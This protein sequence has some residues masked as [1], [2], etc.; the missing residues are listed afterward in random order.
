[1]ATTG[2]V[3]AKSYDYAIYQAVVIKVVWTKQLTF[4]SW[5]ILTVD[6]D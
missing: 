6:Q 5:V 3:R 1:M 4:Y 2:I